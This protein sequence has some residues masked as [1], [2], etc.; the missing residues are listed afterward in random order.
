[1]T[2]NIINTACIDYR[3]TLGSGHICDQ[4]QL[5]IVEPVGSCKSLDVHG[6][7]VVLADE[8]N[9]RYQGDADFTCSA[10]TGIAKL[11]TIDC[12]NGTTHT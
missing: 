10:Q 6:S 8:N 7:T 9:G 2:K 5:P 12:G 11:I 4:E 3:F 1:V